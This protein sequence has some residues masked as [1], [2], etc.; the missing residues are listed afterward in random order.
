MLNVINKKIISFLIENNSISKNEKNLY[1]YYIEIFISLLI[2]GIIVFVL[3]FVYNQ[4]FNSL[5][6]II[7]FKIFRQQLD[8]Y[9]AKTQVQC[10]LLFLP[11]L[12]VYLLTISNYSVGEMIFI[13]KIMFSISILLILKTYLATKQ[14][15]SKNISFENF[16]E[17]HLLI[18]L[19]ILFLLF[20]KIVCFVILYHMHY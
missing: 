11:I 19:I 4:I 12:I 18:L 17:I 3:S 1:F 5:I 7:I 15:L 8:G 13:A 9:H 6:F 14:R 16:S 10:V 20:K 2:N